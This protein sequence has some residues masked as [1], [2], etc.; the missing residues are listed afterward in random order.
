MRSLFFAVLAASLTIATSA[1]SQMTGE[2]WIKLCSDGA[3]VTDLVSCG[4]YLRGVADM[5]QNLQLGAPEVAKACIPYDKSGNDLAK[6]AFP[7]VAKLSASDRAKPASVLLWG[8]FMLAY[9]C[10]SQSQE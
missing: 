6:V 10:R 7:L 4:S 8:A 3:P 1:H 5:I 9:P 2:K